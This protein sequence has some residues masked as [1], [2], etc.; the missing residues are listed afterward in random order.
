M[1]LDK[2]SMIALADE[3]ANNYNANSRESGQAFYDDDDD[4]NGLLT[5]LTNNGQEFEFE[6][7]QDMNARDAKEAGIYNAFITVHHALEAHE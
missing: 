2:D 5:I 7:G 4:E 6:I 3:Q 1:R